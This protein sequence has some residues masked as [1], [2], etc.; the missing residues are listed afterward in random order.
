MDDF[1]KKPL[2][3]YQFNRI[4]IYFGIAF[5]IMILLRFPIDFAVALPIFLLGS[6]WFSS[7]YRDLLLPIL[8]VNSNSGLRSFWDGGLLANTPLRQTI[9]AHREYWHRV[10]K[11]EENIPRLRCGI[12]NLHPAKQDYLPS[13][14]DGV[15]DRKNVIIFHE[16]TQ[17]DENVAVIMSDFIRFAKSLIKL[18]KEN[19]VSEEALRRILKEETKAVYLATGKHWRFEDLT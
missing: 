15:V 12:L 1:N 14:Y 7:W 19:S 13:D 2:I 17:F 9:L 8:R 5:A 10:R 4:T 6:I 18:A 11:L 3:L 16:R